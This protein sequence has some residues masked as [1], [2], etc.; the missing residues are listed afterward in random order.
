METEREIQIKETVTRD[1][2]GSPSKIWRQRV[3]QLKETVTRDGSE[4]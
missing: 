4:S 2:S 3:I 1:G